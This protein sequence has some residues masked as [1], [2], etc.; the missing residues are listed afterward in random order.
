L[1]RRPS[2]AIAALTAL[3]VLSP[4]AACA[5]TV[6]DAPSD[7]DC[8]GNHTTSLLVLAALASAATWNVDE[9]GR[10]AEDLQ[11]SSAGEIIDF[12][13]TWGGGWVIGGG[14]TATFAAGA[15][16]GHEGL[17]ALGTDLLRAYALNGVA[18]LALKGAAD[19]QRPSGGRYS[20]PS[21]HTSSAFCI[22]PVLGHHLGWRAQV[23]AVALGV[24][25]ALGRMQDRHHYLSDVIFGAAL[26]WAAGDLSVRLSGRDDTGG[27]L[28]LAP[29]AVGYT[30]RF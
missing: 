13:N 7:G 3:L 15:L 17:E 9:D 6:A 12:G 1:R 26:G 24:I 2:A 4:T 8:G 19:R 21:G 27:S 14:S 22:A 28:V 23:P 30:G 18:T 5:D 11:S 29:G 10:F 16:G 20:F 25:T